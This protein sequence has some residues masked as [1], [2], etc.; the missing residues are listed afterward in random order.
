MHFL[1]LAGFLGVLY[2][3]TWKFSSSP[4]KPASVCGSCLFA[5]LM[6]I[7]FILVGVVPMSD[8]GKSSGLE[9]HLVP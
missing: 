1:A 2:F 6:L 8:T 3:E 7:L 4:L 9:S 5:A